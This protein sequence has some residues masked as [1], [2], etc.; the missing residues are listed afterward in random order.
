MSSH[1]PLPGTVCFLTRGVLGC[2]GAVDTEKARGGKDGARQYDTS[3][4][5]GVIFLGC[6]HLD[7][8][9]RW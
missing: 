7:G 9:R 5:H 6:W 1:G 3:A 8:M 4:A 2:K